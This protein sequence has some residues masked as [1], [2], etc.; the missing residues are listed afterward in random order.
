MKKDRRCQSCSSSS[1]SS[2][3]SSSRGAPCPF[4]ASASAG[5]FCVPLGCA[6]SSERAGAPRKK[7]EKKTSLERKKTMATRNSRLQRQRRRRPPPVVADADVDCA[8]P[9][10]SS[11]CSSAPLLL[12][13]AD[14][15]ARCCS[16]Q[17]RGARETRPFFLSSEYVF[18]TT[19]KRKSEVIFE[20]RRSFGLLLFFTTPPNLSVTSALFRGPGMTSFPLS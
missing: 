13:A 12:H 5:A 14:S 15:R 16:R 6:A 20:P 9:L 2:P 17:R 10:G 4:L 7:M 19:Q 3:A 8:R 18:S 11:R 1:S